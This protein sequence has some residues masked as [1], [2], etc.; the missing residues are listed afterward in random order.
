MAFNTTKLLLLTFLI[1][2]F[3]N[4]KLTQALKCYS[5]STLAGARHCTL[6]DF[7]GDAINKVDCTGTNAV[8]A[9]LMDKTNSS[10]VVRFCTQQGASIG[11][12]KNEKFRTSGSC[13]TYIGC[14]NFQNSTIEICLC[15]KNLSD[16]KSFEN[17]H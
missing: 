6:D 9:R 16:D 13:F 7:N 14:D 11:I 10:A 5:C 2:I 12:C 8:C 17:C 3:M 15:N 1:Q 4:Y